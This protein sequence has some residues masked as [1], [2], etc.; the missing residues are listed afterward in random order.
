MNTQTRTTN[1]LALLRTQLDLAAVKLATV[2]AE[3]RRLRRMTENGKQGRLLYRTAADARQIVGWRFAGYSVTRRACYGYGMSERRW[4]WA[5]A[6]L[7]V[8]KVLDINT[9]CVDE[10]D[11]ADLDEALAQVDRAV[12]ICEQEGLARLVFRLP[13]GRAKPPKR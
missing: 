7:K 11:V 13:R 5:V 4:A 6:L 12:T 8:A 9:A 3:N 10:F 1:D 2:Q